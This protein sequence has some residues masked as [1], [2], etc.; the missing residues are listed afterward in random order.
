[1]LFK[2][3]CVFKNE[4]F[5]FIS[6]GVPWEILHFGSDERFSKAFFICRLLSYGWFGSHSLIYLVNARTKFYSDNVEYFFIL[7]YILHSQPC[8]YNCIMATWSILIRFWVYYNCRTI[9]HSVRWSLFYIWL[10][11]SPCIYF[12]CRF[13]ITDWSSVPFCN[14]VSRLRALSSHF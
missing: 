8:M 4:D 12:I 13:I 2:L 11:S 14:L 3:A 9:F 6:N 7:C 5:L 1:M 10:Y